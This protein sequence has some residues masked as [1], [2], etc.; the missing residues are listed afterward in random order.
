MKSSS[1]TGCWQINT[2]S[3]AKYGSSSVDRQRKHRIQAKNRQPWHGPLID[4]WHITGLHTLKMYLHRSPTGDEVIYRERTPNT[5]GARCYRSIFSQ[6]PRLGQGSISRQTAEGWSET[7]VRLLLIRHSPVFFP[8]VSHGHV[9]LRLQENTIAEYVGES[10][11][12]TDTT[13]SQIPAKNFR[14]E[15]TRTR[16][17]LSSNSRS[18]S[19]TLVL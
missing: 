4:L 7:L 1:T 11:T 5:L 12:W 6:E 13:V 17:T 2:L 16:S 15:Q 9:I 10:S 18:C 19:E 3:A 8:F 14:C